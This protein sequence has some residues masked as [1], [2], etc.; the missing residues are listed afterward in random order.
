MFIARE[1]HY[2]ALRRSAM[3]FRVRRYKHFAPVEQD[4]ACF[5]HGEGYFFSFSC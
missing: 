4:A 5:A 1:Y 2:I 3:C